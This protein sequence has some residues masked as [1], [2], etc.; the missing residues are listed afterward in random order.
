MDNFLN[1]LAFWADRHSCHVRQTVTD[2]MIDIDWLTM[3]LTNSYWLI[4]TN[5]LWWNYMTITDWQQLTM[6]Y[7]SVSQQLENNFGLYR[8][9]DYLLLTDK[10]WLTMN[11][12]SEFELITMTWLTVS[13]VK[14]FTN[15][16]CQTHCDII[17]LIKCQLLTDSDLETLA[18]WLND[19]AS[20]SA[21]DAEAEWCQL[22]DS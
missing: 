7:M 2:V 5:W 17:T 19:S 14:H 22:D 20:L 6:I 3:C 1:N 15:L 12:L 9:T 18:A 11:Y 13:N 4:V 8:V 21:T 10:D 16:T